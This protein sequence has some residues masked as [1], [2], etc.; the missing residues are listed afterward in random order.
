MLARYLKD[1]ILRVL[2]AFYYAK[3]ANIFYPPIFK[4]E[5]PI[6][7]PK[8]PIQGLQNR[9]DKSPKKP[10]QP[11][12]QRKI[13][14]LDGF[15]KPKPQTPKVDKNKK[16]P[17]QAH[18]APFSFHCDECMNTYDQDENSFDLKDCPYSLKKPQSV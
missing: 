2:R 16:P 7:F 12:T 10:N 15:I 6:E 8:T 1:F 9:L 5:P 17:T 4:K 18:C 3:G 11:K 13:Q 14:G